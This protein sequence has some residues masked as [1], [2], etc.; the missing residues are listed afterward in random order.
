MAET[1]FS[2]PDFLSQLKRLEPSAVKKIV[3]AYNETIYKAAL[4]QSLNSSEALEV[5]Q[6]TWTSFFDAVTQFEARSHIRTFIFGILYNKIK[7]YKRTESKYSL[8]ED[9]DS[10]IDS[11][12]EGGWWRESPA[13]PEDFVNGLEKTNYIQKCLDALVENQKIAFYL[14]EVVGESSKEICKILEVSSTNLGVLI[15]RAK[16][17]MRKCIE[18][19][20]NFEGSKGESI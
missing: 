19:K 1:N 4:G 18:T 13:S 8:V 16:S 7:E 2:D 15:F 20:M 5:V 3:E 17:H 11:Q 12:Y 10:I 6:N 9:I 14:K